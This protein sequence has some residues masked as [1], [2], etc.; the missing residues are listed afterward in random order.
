M[1]DGGAEYSGR[2]GVTRRGKPA[3]TE[4]IPPF[5]CKIPLH[6]LHGENKRT[7]S[8]EMTGAPEIL[9]AVEGVADALVLV[10]FLPRRFQ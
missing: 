2:D 5:Q 3:R 4:E 10:P 9:P 6:W 7:L 8:F 1:C